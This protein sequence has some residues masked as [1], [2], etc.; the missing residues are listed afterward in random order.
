MIEKGYRYKD[1]LI[2]ARRVEDYETILK[3]LFE[4]ANL[5]VFYDKADEM[6]HHPFADFI[7]S[8]F[9]IKFHYWRYP[10]L[11]R[12]LRTEL[13]LP[14]TEEELSLTDRKEQVTF[15]RD[16]IDKTENI[17]LAF[18][19]EGNAWFKKTDWSAYQFIELEEGEE[20]PQQPLG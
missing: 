13:F 8:L 20:T 7:D 19:Y 14:Q 5:N 18:G 9:R 12:M 10:D 4:K 16:T 11:M 2:M 17:M 3:P 1:F 15:Y 6:Q